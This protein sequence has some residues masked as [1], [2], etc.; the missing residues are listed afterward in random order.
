MILVPSR[1]CQGD[2][3]EFSSVQPARINVVLQLVLTLSVRKCIWTVKSWVLVCLFGW[4]GNPPQGNQELLVVRDKVGRPPG[5]LGVSKF[6][7]VI[8]FPSVLWPVKN[9]MLACEK[10]CVGLL[11]VTI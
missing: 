1:V 6:V 8:F 4:H 3:L 5:E 10:L 7:N 2:R 9:W 11:V